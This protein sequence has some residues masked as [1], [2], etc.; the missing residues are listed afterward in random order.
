M[1]AEHGQRTAHGEMTL[2]RIAKEP[3]PRRRVR[4]V[5]RLLALPVVAALVFLRDPSLFEAPRFWAEEGTNYFGSAVARSGLD[6]L[7]N[8]QA[9]PHNPY[10]HWI[11]QLA[12]VAAAHWVPLELA[13][14]VTTF[15]WAVVLLAY[16]LAALFGRAE[17][18]HAPWRRALAVA[19]PLL[20][21]SDSENWANTLG[22]H[23][24]CDLALVLLLLEAGAVAGRR[25]AAGIA[26]FAVLSVL[27]PT[28]WFLV[29]AAALLARKDW[30]TYRPY[31][32]VLAGAAALEA[33]VSFACFPSRARTPPDLVYAPHIVVSKL[34]LWPIAGWRT[35]TD[36]SDWVLRL[37]ED[38]VP[39]SALAVFVALFLSVA[40]LLRFIRRDA[41]TLVL[42]ATYSAA[43]AAYLLLGIGVGRAHI[44]LFNGGRY[45]WYPNA[46]F[47]MI[48]AH[49]VDFERRSVSQAIVA[50]VFAVALVTGVKEFR[51]PRPV[52]EFSLAPS[53]R[54]EVRHHREDRDYNLLRIAPPGW[55]VPVPPEP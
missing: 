40:V 22:A 1:R 21:V 4:S 3:P 50:V 30:K 41:T 12:T 42:I 31:V 38:A 39:S 11:P 47:L 36:Y 14:W 45:A 5:A 24:Y 54:D 28:S 51:Y 23:F 15:A 55:V 32:G 35:A 26:A 9:A 25:R 44:P 33:T 6:G 19:L 52:V 10:P 27:S 20:A 49:Q 16:E 7:L 17:L 34:V 43:V 53:W 29:P 8:I 2:D 18:L 48:L 37:P 46:L 13:P